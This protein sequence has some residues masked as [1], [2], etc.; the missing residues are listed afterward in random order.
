MRRKGY[1]IAHNKSE[2]ENTPS[3]RAPK[4]LGIF[5][6][7]NLAFADEIQSAGPQPTLAEMVRTAIQLLQYNAK[8]YLLVV[9]AGL[10]GKAASQNEGETNAA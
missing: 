7:A 4:L 6:S 1:D 8:G 10:A 9:D 5:S 2:L 3:W